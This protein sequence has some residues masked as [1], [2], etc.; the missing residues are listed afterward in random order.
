MWDL[1]T[2]LTS[3]LGFSLLQGLASALFLLYLWP[4]SFTWV[5]SASAT[6]P[7][8]LKDRDHLSHIFSVGVLGASDQQAGHPE[9]QEATGREDSQPPIGQG[10]YLGKG[11]NTSYCCSQVQK[12]D[13]NVFMPKSFFFLIC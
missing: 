8:V 12:K 11:L 6:R 1:E 4:D 2:E 9:S 3:A 13:T 10:L 5:C 7:Y